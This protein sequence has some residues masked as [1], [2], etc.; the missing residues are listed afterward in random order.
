MTRALATL[1]EA[2]VA[3]IMQLAEDLP[4]QLHWNDKTLSVHSERAECHLKNAELPLFC[5]ER[6]QVTQELKEGL[7][8]LGSI[9]R[10][11]LIPL[12]PLRL[13][14]ASRRES[15]VRLAV[16][17]DPPAAL[18]RYLRVSLELPVSP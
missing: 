3:V 13:I 1:R 5:I 2:K 4:P 11:A 10:F 9:W 15:A 8:A 16:A 17:W 7:S 12:R 14:L 18:F 6:R